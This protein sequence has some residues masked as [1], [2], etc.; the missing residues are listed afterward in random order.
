MSGLS[1][2]MVDLFDEIWKDLH[3]F[4]R[5][6]ES[7]YPSASFPP[8]N[9]WLDEEQKDL[10]LEFAVAGINQDDIELDTEGDYLILKIERK[11]A[12]REGLSLLQRGISKAKV[13]TRYY[14]PASKY[15]LYKIEAHTKNGILAVKIP[16]REVIKPNKILIEH[17]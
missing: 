15:D 11:D 2:S 13:H 10:Y 5:R 3:G 16:A 7:V 17:K 6:H 8:M 9:V 4:E 14:V 12:Q 1:L